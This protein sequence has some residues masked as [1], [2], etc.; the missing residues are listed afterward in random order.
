MH[1]KEYYLDIKKNEIVPFV[2]TWMDFKG[3]MLNELSQIEKETI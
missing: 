3:M 2:L 1:T